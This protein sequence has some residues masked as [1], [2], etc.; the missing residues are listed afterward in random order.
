[1]VKNSLKYNT[2]GNLFDKDLITAEQILALGMTADI[3]QQITGNFDS[4]DD[5]NFFDSYNLEENLGVKNIKAT[6]LF[7]DGKKTVDV[8]FGATSAVK[9]NSEEYDVIN[10]GSFYDRVTFFAMVGHILQNIRYHF[11]MV[12]L[13]KEYK[14]PNRFEVE[15]VFPKNENHITSYYKKTLEFLRGETFS[16]NEKAI[17]IICNTDRCL[18][19]YKFLRK[20]KVGVEHSSNLIYAFYNENNE[21]LPLYTTSLSGRTINFTGES[22]FG[23]SMFKRL[24]LSNTTDEDKLSDEETLQS[25][26]DVYDKDKRIF[27]FVNDASQLKSENSLVKFNDDLSDYIKQ[28][29]VSGWFMQFTPR[30]MELIKDALFRP[31]ISNLLIA[32]QVAFEKGNPFGINSYLIQSINEVLNSKAVQKRLKLEED[33]KKQKAEVISENEEDFEENNDFS[34]KH[35]DQAEDEEEHDSLLGKDEEAS[36]NE[37]NKTISEEHSYEK[38]LTKEAETESSSEETTPTEIVSEKDSAEKQTDKHQKPK[39]DNFFPKK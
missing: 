13:K 33:L 7:G 19:D 1:M 32:D 17:K 5:K 14:D 18:N 21:R 35:S 8:Y 38:N 4:F 22:F 24:L 15:L 26:L 34:D 39:I 9:E 36:N 23:S 31:S 3:F 25:A 11:P 37:E 20:V 2:L 16:K 28:N 29:I 10:A 27:S 6:P 30:E 12:L